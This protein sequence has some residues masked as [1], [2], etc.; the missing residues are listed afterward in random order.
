MMQFFSVDLIDLLGQVI[1]IIFAIFVAYKDSV[2]N[3]KISNKGKIAITGL[4]VSAI[5]T[6]ILKIMSIEEKYNNEKIQKLEAESQ[7]RIKEIERKND[8]GFQHDVSQS[9][10]SSVNKLHDLKNDLSST[11]TGLQDINKLQTDASLF[12]FKQL[13]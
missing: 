11:L 8:L 4:V 13:H 5:F 1:A 9:F 12:S 3:G 10:E 7:L 2:K 6:S